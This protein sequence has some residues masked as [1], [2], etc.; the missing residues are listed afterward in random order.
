MQS[1][2]IKSTFFMNWNVNAL[3][4]L[5][6][7]LILL[8]IGSV[9]GDKHLTTVSF[10]KWRLGCPWW[11]LGSLLAPSFFS[12]NLIMQLSCCVI[13][14]ESSWDNHILILNEFILISEEEKWLPSK[15]SLPHKLRIKAER[16]SERWQYNNSYAQIL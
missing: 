11:I 12:L 2:K 7:C 3:L 13:L 16:E 10:V 1:Y 6:K 14:Y 5:L 4:K 15:T 9:T 8:L